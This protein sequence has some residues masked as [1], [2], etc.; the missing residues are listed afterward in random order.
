MD[1]RFQLA[2]GVRAQRETLFGG[3]ASADQPVDGLAR[4]HDPDRTFCQPGRRYRQYLMVPQSLAAEAAAHEGGQDADLILLDAE[5][6]GEGYGRRVDHLRRVMD[7]KPV[8]VPQDRGCVRLDRIVI[9]PGRAIDGI[10][11]VRRLGKRRFGIPDG[12][13]I[14]L[15]QN[16]SRGLRYGFALVEARAGGEG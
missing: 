10:D 6:P 14:L 3:G 15:D 7:Q 16:G 12:D 5:N 9:L 1:D 2:V 4:Q 13:R 8:A 11:L